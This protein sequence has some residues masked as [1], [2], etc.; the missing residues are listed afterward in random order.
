MFNDKYIE[1]T[2]NG[3]KTNVVATYCCDYLFGEKLK[4]EGPVRLAHF[5]A[6]SG[7]QWKELVDAFN[8]A[9]GGN[10]AGVFDRTTGEI[11]SV[12]SRKEHGGA[13]YNESC[14]DFD[15]RTR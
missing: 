11:I 3:V 7:R 4:L 13:F 1:L 8:T 5:E 10:V 2:V 6:S 14:M 15:R 9:F 12:F